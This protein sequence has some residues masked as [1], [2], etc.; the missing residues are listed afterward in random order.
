VV[1]DESVV[2]V[3]SFDTVML[4]VIVAKTT[5][6]STVA[7]VIEIVGVGVDVSELW[8]FEVLVDG[9]IVAS[10]AEFID[11]GAPPIIVTSAKAVPNGVIKLVACLVQQSP[12]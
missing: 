2:V 12:T 8:L 10:T 5:V 11:E 9:V 7:V 3:S 6:P 1:D 4:E